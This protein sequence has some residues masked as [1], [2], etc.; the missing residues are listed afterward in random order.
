MFLL[1]LS[2]FFSQLRSMSSTPQKIYTAFY[3]PKLKKQLIN[4]TTTHTIKTGSKA[5]K[6]KPKKLIKQPNPNTKHNN[7]TPLT[8]PLLTAKWRQRT[9]TG[10]KCSACQQRIF[11]S[12]KMCS[13]TLHQGHHSQ[14]RRTSHPHPINWANSHICHKPSYVILH[15]PNYTSSL[16]IWTASSNHLWSH[17]SRI[18]K[19]K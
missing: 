10:Q 11:F 12:H 4:M 3:Q 7:S 8:T 5:T 18:N 1:Y 19:T 17:P 16:K 2:F 9:K 14:K 6:I 13:C 15:S